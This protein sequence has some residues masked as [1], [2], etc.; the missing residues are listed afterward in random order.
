MPNIIRLDEGYRLDEGHRL[1]EPPFNPPTPPAPV[2]PR[3]EKGKHMDM[4]PS[5]RADQYVWYKNISDNVVAEAVKFAGDPAQA[6]AAK[7]AADAILA[8]MDATNTQAN[9]LAS[10]RQLEADTK[11]ANDAIIR[12]IVRNWKTLSGYP[13]SGSEAILR[14]KGAADPFD[15]ATFKP[16]LKVTVEPGQNRLSFN[17]AGCDGVKVWYRQRGTLPWF[18]IGYDS[19]APYFDTTPLTA[20]AVAEV[21]EYKI[22]GVIDDVEIGLESDIVSAPFAG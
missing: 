16:S 15:P 7:A 6:L 20:P 5:K 13:A 8:K 19:S 14:L 18:F 10:L 12:G 2:T 21:R 17:L 22:R 9:L 4:I 3:K 11:T 1:D